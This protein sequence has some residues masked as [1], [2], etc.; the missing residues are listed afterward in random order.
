MWARVLRGAA[1][2]AAA[3]TALNAVTYMDMDAAGA[4]GEQHTQLTPGGEMLDL[5]G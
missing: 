1:A 2:G 3:T 4:S 5:V